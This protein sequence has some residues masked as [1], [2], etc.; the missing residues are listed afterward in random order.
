VD[1]AAPFDDPPMVVAVGRRS[2]IEPGP[3]LAP[4]PSSAATRLRAVGRAAVGIAGFFGLCEAFT[5]L[6]LVNP[7]FLPPAS[8]VLA[9]FLGL[10]GNTDFL[11]NVGA[12]LQAWA[13]GMGFAVALAV[14]VGIVLGSSNVAYRLSRTVIEFLRPVPA[15]AIIPLLILLFGQGL[16]MKAWLIAYAAIWPILFNAIYAVHDVD[17]VA[18]DTARAFG[19]SRFAILRRVALP[20]AAPFIATGVRISAGIGL[21]VGISAELIAG[22]DEGIGAWILV[23]S[24]APGNADI[25]FAGAV[26]AA[27]LGYLLNLVLEGSERWLFGWSFASRRRGS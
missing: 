9:R 12:T 20:S 5:R 17:P 24:F 13:V 26:F 23:K 3:S 27:M 6:E 22:G 16:R 14:P 8:T 10:F 25:V 1:G 21:L 11:H 2:E 4:R 19:C 15:I 7:R 18:K